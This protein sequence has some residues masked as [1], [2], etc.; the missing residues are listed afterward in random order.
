M[1]AAAF[2]VERDGPHCHAG[3]GV[4]NHQ[5]ETR[6]EQH[7]KEQDDDVVALHGKRA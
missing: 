6:Q 2:F 4:L 1:S 3:T 5:P 7:R